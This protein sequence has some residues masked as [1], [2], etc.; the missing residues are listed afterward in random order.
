MGIFCPKKGCGAANYARELKDGSWKC[1]KCGYVRAKHTHRWTTAS[2]NVAQVSEH[3]TV[4]GCSARRDRDP[5]PTEKKQI[6]ERLRSF[7]R[8]FNPR[9]KD[10]IHRVWHDFARRFVLTDPE[11]ATHRFKVT[12]YEL[13]CQIEKWATKYPNDVTVLRC[14]D[15]MYMGA[16]L[17]CIDHKARAQWHGMTVVFVNQQGH[18]PTKFFLYPGHVKNFLKHL[19]RTDKL[20]TVL[21]RKEEAE[22]RRLRKT[23]PFA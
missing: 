8:K 9:S 12:G 3:C 22:R 19:V 23:N 2:Y 4:S 6:K 13:M 16:D 7:R 14:D 10:N 15:D 21:E 18:E 20:T 5:T 11:T 17:V 1:R